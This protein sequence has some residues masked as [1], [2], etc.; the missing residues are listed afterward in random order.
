MNIRDFM[1]RSG[2]RAEGCAIYRVYVGSR[3]PAQ[4]QLIT[5]G[6]KYFL[7]KQREASKGLTANWKRSLS[8]SGLAKSTV[9]CRRR[10]KKHRRYRRRYDSLT[11][12]CR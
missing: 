9:S 3:N 12:N 11:T 8:E 4:L 2:I 7:R 1:T 5:R 10:S 6:Q